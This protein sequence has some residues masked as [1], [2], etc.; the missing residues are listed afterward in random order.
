MSP[1]IELDPKIL[2]F[3]TP[4]VLVCTENSDRSFN[5]APISSAWALGRTIVLGLGEDGHTISNL[6]SR[7]E[8]TLNYPEPHLWP[9]VERLASLTGANPVPPTKPVRTTFEANKFAAARL[10]SQGSVGVRPPRVQECGIQL[11][12]RATVIS[13]SGAGEFA[14]VECQVEKIHVRESLVLPNTQHIDPMQWEPLIYNFRHYF[15]LG[16][17]QGFSYRSETPGGRPKTQL[18]SS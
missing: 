8:L 1:H 4:V 17:E 9:A 15:G 7:P 6:R 11:E 16:P 10:N 18:G 13:P 5:L 14:V 3:G 2:Y 12:A